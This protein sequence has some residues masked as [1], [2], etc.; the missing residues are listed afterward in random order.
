MIAAPEHWR[1]W[2][3]YAVFEEDEY[4]IVRFVRFKDNA[5]DYIRKEI[6]EYLE[7][8]KYMHQMMCGGD[9]ESR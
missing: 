1:E 6:T 2:D 3:E 9:R 8:K 4:H 7:T 5:P